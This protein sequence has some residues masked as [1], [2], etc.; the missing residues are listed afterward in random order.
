MFLRI[1]DHFVH[2]VSDALEVNFGG[3]AYGVKENGTEF[4]GK[5]KSKQKECGTVVFSSV[6]SN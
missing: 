1:S 5:R 2:H 4:Y 6:Q 3:F